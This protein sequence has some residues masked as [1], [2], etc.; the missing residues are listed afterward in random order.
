VTQ[1][2]KI[3]GRSRSA[4]LSKAVGAALGRRLSRAAS[5]DALQ[6]LVGAAGESVVIGVSVQSATV[7]VAVEAD[8]EEGGEAQEGVAL[9]KVPSPTIVVVTATASA[10]PPA[11]A[12]A[13]EGEEGATGPG[14]VP[15]RPKELKRE[16]SRMSVLGGKDWFKSVARRFRRKSSR[17]S[18]GASAQ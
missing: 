15:V 17:E 6:G 8:A 11:A 12:A 7:H 5:K 4:T 1:I 13:A 14:A 16:R 18:V 10:D 2:T 9:A 3:P